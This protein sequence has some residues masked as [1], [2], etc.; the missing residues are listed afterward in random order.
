MGP[1]QET[2]HSVAPSTTTTIID[3]AFPPE[4]E[5]EIQRDEERLEDYG[6]DDPEEPPEK[7]LDVVEDKKVVEK[8]EE[9]PNLVKWDGLHDPENPHTWSRAYRWWITF[10]VTLATL[11]VYVCPFKYVYFALLNFW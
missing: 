8:A 3:H 5:A 10:V 4:L 2:I 6:A 7:R 1:R 9:D 11:N